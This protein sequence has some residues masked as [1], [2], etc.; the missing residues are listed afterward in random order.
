GSGPAGGPCGGPHCCGGS[1]PAC[2]A[3]LPVPSVPPLGVVGSEDP[4]GSAGRGRANGPS[5][6]SISGCPGGGCRGGSC[7]DASDGGSADAADSCGRSWGSRCSSGVV[8]RS[9]MET[10]S[11]LPC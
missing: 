2:G 8:L 7:V 11:A 10:E 3:R 6:G 5:G 9:L 1:G 4:A